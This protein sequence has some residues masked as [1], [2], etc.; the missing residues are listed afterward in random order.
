MSVKLGLRL[1]D[2]FTS[3]EFFIAGIIAIMIIVVGYPLIWT[4][5]AAFG[6]NH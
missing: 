3:G 5:F 4:A 6:T 2:H 1:R